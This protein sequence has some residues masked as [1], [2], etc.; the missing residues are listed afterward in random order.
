MVLDLVVA[1]S[2]GIV[3]VTAVA[4]YPTLSRIMLA[5][6]CSANPGKSAAVVGKAAIAAAMNMG[7]QLLALLDEYLM[8]SLGFFEGRDGRF[9]DDTNL[10]LHG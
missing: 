6:R 4:Q 2:T 9:L 7:T 8:Y 3:L 1:S 10:L 5:T